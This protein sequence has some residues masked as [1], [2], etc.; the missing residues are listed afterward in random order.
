[1]TTVQHKGFVLRHGDTDGRSSHRGLN[2]H[3]IEQAHRVGEALAELGYRHLILSSPYVRTR[4]TAEIIAEHVDVIS[5][6]CL[7]I[8]REHEGGE[9]RDEMRERAWIALQIACGLFR[10]NPIVISHREPIRA[11]VATVFN[12]NPKNLRAITVPNV[13]GFVLDFGLSPQY[14]NAKMYYKSWQK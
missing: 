11:M 14:I 8:L 5:L 3:G 12:K 6:E 1:M 13:G 9:S 10:F 7:H 4:Q 2:P